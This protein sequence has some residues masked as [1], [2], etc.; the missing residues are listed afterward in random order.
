[1]NTIEKT[2]HFDFGPC[3]DNTKIRMSIYGLAVINPN[4]T[5]VAYDKATNQIIDVEL[6]SMKNTGKY[7][8][9][10]PTAISALAP[11]DIV[12]HNHHPMFIIEIT[13][14]N[15]IVAVD[16]YAGEEKVILP[17]TSPFGFN[18]VTKVICL[19]DTMIANN[20][21]S[22]ENPF[23]NMLPYLMLSGENEFNPMMLLAMNG[24]MGNINPLM[25][26]ALAGDG[27]K[28]NPWMMMALCQQGGM[29]NMFNM[30]NNHNCNCGCH[31]TPSN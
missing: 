17:T 30:N 28:M 29:L 22:A 9:K 25:L 14:E 26:M 21:P 7:I 2:M 3:S 13:R 1:M 20:S 16:P 31:D 19:F 10:I 23:G 11:G 4:G 24:N 27:E 18:F 8:Y 6:L 12:I 15:K 5:W